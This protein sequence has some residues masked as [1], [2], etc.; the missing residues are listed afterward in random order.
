MKPCSDQPGCARVKG[1]GFRVWGLGFKVYGLRFRAFGEAWQVKAPHKK[2]EP[3]SYI[4]C[5][6]SQTLNPEALNP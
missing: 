6:E 1:L 4:L 5:P 3:R 2:D